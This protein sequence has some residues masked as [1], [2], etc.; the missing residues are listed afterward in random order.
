M[1]GGYE[2][3]NYRIRPNPEQLKLQIRSQGKTSGKIYL[4]ANH[5]PLLP[6]RKLKWRL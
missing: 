6:K 1:S 4:A 3:K 2:P 5:H